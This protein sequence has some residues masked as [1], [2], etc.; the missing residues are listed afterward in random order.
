MWAVRRLWAL[1]GSAAGGGEEGEVEAG[2]EEVL[3]EAVEEGGGFPV[4]GEAFGVAA[5]FG[6]GWHGGEA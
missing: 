6:V 2:V 3:L 5:D 4:A 1:R